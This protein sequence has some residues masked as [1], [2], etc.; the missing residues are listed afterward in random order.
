MSSCCV[1]G[2]QYWRSNGS[3]F[4]VY[5]IPAAAVSPTTHLQQTITLPDIVC[6]TNTSIVTIALV[7][8]FLC[9]LQLYTTD[10]TQ[11]LGELH[12][13]ISR[14]ETWH[15]EAA[16]MVAGD[17]DCVNLRKVLTHYQRYISCATRSAAMLDHVYTVQRSIQ[18]HS[19]IAIRPMGPCLDPAVPWLQIQSEAGEAVLFT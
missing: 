10:I 15:S 4:K 1:V 6:T 5:S 8:Y 12:T 13:V 19:P 7:W 18:I 11:A 16:L 9:C 2:S 14:Q 3:K 17:F